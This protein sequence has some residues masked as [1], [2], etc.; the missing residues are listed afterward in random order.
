MLDS[1]KAR[2][3][4]VT[5]RVSVIRRSDQRRVMAEVVLHNTDDYQTFAANAVVS[6]REAND[7]FV[8]YHGFAE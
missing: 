2:S 6:D 1:P 4:K 7:S 3:N 5:V 8:R